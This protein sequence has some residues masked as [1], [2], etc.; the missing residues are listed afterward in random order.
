[1][2]PAEQSHRRRNVLAGLEALDDRGAASRPGR[3]E[4]SSADLPSASLLDGSELRS[5]IRRRGPA[6]AL[7]PPGF[8]GIVALVVLNRGSSAVSGATG[9]VLAVLGAPA[10]LIAGVPLRP[11]SGT[12]VVALLSSGALWLLLGWWAA[13]RASSSPAPQWGTYWSEL[14]WMAMSVWAGLALSAL[15]SSLAVGRILF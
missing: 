11:G 6:L 1:M 9:F 10:L 3:A 14:A 12:I 8:L 4:P 5:Q 15:L 13:R 2:E 7:V